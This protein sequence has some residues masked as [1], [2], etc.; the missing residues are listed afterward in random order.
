MIT[1]RAFDRLAF[2]ATPAMYVVGIALGVF[3]YLSPLPP[4]RRKAR[5]PVGPAADFEGG[6]VERVEFNGRAIYVLRGA[7]SIVAVDAACTH[8][9]CNVNWHEKDASFVCPCHGARFDREGKA[10]RKPGVGALRRQKHV[11]AGGEVVLLDE[12]GAVARG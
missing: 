11:I 8:L 1:R 4:P 7:D 6:K 3:K 2:I 10:T 5:L 12:P 9:N